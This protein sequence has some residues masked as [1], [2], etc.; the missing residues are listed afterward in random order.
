MTFFNK[1]EDVIDIKLTRY[2]REK[3]AKGELKP[4][5]YAFFDDEILYDTGYAGY[6]E[7]QQHA[8]L[9]IQDETPSLR[10]QPNHE[11]AEIAATTLDGTQQTGDKHYSLSFPLGSSA[12]SSEYRPAWDLKF[13]KGELSG[14]VNYVTGSHQNMPIPQLDVD[15]VY[16]TLVRDINDEKGVLPDHP[17][18]EIFRADKT[19]LIST[20]FPDGTY[21]Q[22]VQDPVLIDIFEDNTEFELENVSIEF[23]EIQRVD[24]SGSIQNPGAATSD[25]TKKI[26]YKPLKFKKKTSNIVNDLLIPDAEDDLTNVDVDPNYIEYYLDVLVDREIPEQEICEGIQKL[27]ARE[28]EVDDFL[29]DF[30]CEPFA[31]TQL[32]IYD[33]DIIEENEPDCEETENCP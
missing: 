16:K 26:I 3:L 10:T 30:D 5:Y 18:G 19:T 2:G 20:V 17:E 14:S 32:D 24:M 13:M 12:L 29:Q 22:V 27:K 11:G 4:K 9:R 31:T 33:S 25:L 8:Q 7:N 15:I 23:Y 6:T 1:K 21:L 28:L